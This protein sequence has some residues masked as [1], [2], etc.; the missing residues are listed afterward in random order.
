M[1]FRL[2]SFLKF[3]SKSKNEHGVH[4]PFVFSYVTQCLYSKQKFDQDKT[5]D[6]LLKSIGYFNIKTLYINENPDFEEL[7]KAQ[8]PDIRPSE[9]TVDLLFTKH[10]DAYGLDRLLSSGKLH[11]DSMVLIDSIHEDPESEQEWKDLIE[12]PNISVSMD[13]F[14]CGV[15][16]VRKEQV[17]E[18]FTIR[19]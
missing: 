4:S 18:H 15:L 6:V 16:F 9:N 7:V 2:F 3:L 10:L 13:L 1:W 12:S 14:H 19:I 11:N 5:A 8:Y 17:K